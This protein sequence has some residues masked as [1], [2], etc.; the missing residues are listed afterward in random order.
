MKKILTLLFIVIFTIPSLARKNF[1]T[2][3]VSLDGCRWDYPELYDTPFINYMAVNGV[4]SGLIPSYPSKTFPNHYTLATGLYPDHHGIIANS[5]VNRKDGEVFSL[6]NPKTKTDSKYYKG[7][8]VWIT[9]KKQ[10]KRVYTYHWPGSDVKLKDGYPDVFFNYDTNHLSV[11]ERI[12][13][14]SQAIN[15][16]Q[17]PDLIMVYFEEPDHTG[18]AFGPQDVNTKNAIRNMD[19]MLQDLWDN[20]QNGP[21]KDSVNLIVVSDHGMTMVTP[22]RK[23]ECRKYLKPYWFDRIE[24]NLPAQ[25][26]CKKQYIDSVYNALKDIPHQRVWRRNEIPA[27]LHYDSNKNIGDVVVSPD[28]GWLVYDQ[29]V[30]T[31]GM[32]GYDP[33]YSDMHAIF[34]AMGPDFKKTEIPHFR[35]VDIYDLM[36]HLLNIT[37]AKND[38]NLEEIKSILKN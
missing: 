30:T 27:Y 34:R 21:R 32:H 1:Y 20:V 11:S 25:I 10:G 7:E 19:G 36:C 17:A 5:F 24:G 8:P 35:N 14:A 18:H 37:P 38:G 28:E 33:E 29:E 9:A 2:I 23:I 22:D 6:S 3:I 4:K 13:L 15:S 31:G 12:T 26:Y 16:K